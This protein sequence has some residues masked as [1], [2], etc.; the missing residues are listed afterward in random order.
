[1]TRSFGQV[2]SGHHDF[3]LHCSILWQTAFIAIAALFRQISMSP[4]TAYFH[5]DDYCQ[6]ELLPVQNWA[7]CAQELGRIGEFS[8]A[9][10]APNDAG[11]DAM[12][13][14]SHAPLSIA[15][16][17]I[18]FAGV[19][20]A[21][22]LHLPQFETVET[23][24][25]SYSEKCPDTSA[26]GYADSSIIFVAHNDTGH[27]A[28]IWLSVGPVDT[29]EKEANF[30]ASLHALD[31]LGPL[32]L[33]DWNWNALLRLHDA[34]QVRDYLRDHSAAAQNAQD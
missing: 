1:M 7:H 29:P 2:A 27:V 26:F 28:A 32:L 24:Y 19:S 34:D 13:M 5:E 18:D 11:W 17:G 23:G 30:L 4:R 8:D 22:A 9:H 21:L 12:Y 14:R 10:R 6:I 3:T 16:L 15:A 33:V 25:G 31:A 20:N